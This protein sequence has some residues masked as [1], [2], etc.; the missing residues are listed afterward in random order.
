MNSAIARWAGG[1]LAASQLLT[2]GQERA[3]AAPIAPIKAPFDMPQLQRPVFP[4]RSFNITDYG[5]NGDGTTKNTDAFR[6]AIAACHAAGGG[7]VLVPRGKWFT[8]AIHFKS[9]VNLHLQEGAEI[10]FSDEPSDYLPPVFVRYAGRECWNYSPLLYARDCINIAV[11]GRGSLY[12]HGQRWWQWSGMGRKTALEVQTYKRQEEMVS[13]K[14]PV[15]ERIMPNG[16]QEGFRP[17]LIQPIN[18]TNVL[19]E[20]F[21]IAQP[22]PFW[23]VQF[24]YCE[25]VIA[26]ELNIQ[27]RG[28]PNTD[29]FDLDSTRNALIED[30][31]INAG[32]DCICLK[33]GMDED[34][35]RVG[36]PTENI[37]V[38]NCRTRSG[39]GGV[40]IGSDMSGGVRNVWAHDCDFSGT[41]KGIRMKTMRGRGGV[42]ENLYF[43][44][45]TMN[46]VGDGIHI[47]TFYHSTPVEAVSERTPT[48]RNIHIS[49]ITAHSVKKSTISVTGLPERSV[50][51]LVLENITMDGA[52]GAQFTDAE[53]LKLVN[54]RLTPAK[55]P[56]FALRNVAAMSLEKSPSPKG[57]SLFL[58][59]NGERTKNLRLQDCD[60]SGATQGITFGKEVPAQTRG[61]LPT[62]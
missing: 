31:L 33:S 1:V 57:A 50:T 58:N 15:A 36:R 52:S 43:E 53:D 13:A 35:R 61:E 4:E 27:T 41:E 54:V 21:T 44:N 38:R 30:C 10:H 62:S 46:G 29:G 17:Q 18:C 24:A 2:C 28:G 11:T 40:V 3:A 48:F 37:V 23:T 19:L 51:G 6:K 22:G 47:T 56:V 12:G 55:G 9:N 5:A 59:V 25:N 49:N 32:D 26:R 16:Q 34:G 20:G 14:V 45:L 8:G 42:V 7:T 60:Y 39:H